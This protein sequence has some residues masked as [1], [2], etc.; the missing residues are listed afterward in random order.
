MSTPTVDPPPPPSPFDREAVTA[1]I[2][3][4]HELAAGCEGVLT[5]LPV[6]ENSPPHPQRFRIGDVDGMVAA[7]MSYSGVP[8]CNLYAPFATMC[9]SVLADEAHKNRFH[10]VR[11]Y[12][13]GLHW[14]GERRLDE[15]L[16]KYLGAA[17]SDYSTAIGKMFLVALVARIFEPGCKSD[18]MI[19]LEGPQGAMKSAACRVIAGEWFSDS[20]PEVRGSKDLA[21][22]LRG[23]WLIEVSELS[24]MTR[25]ETNTLKAFVTREK[26]LY[27]PPYGRHEVIEPR[28]CLFVGTVN[29]HEYLRDATGGRR[30]WPLG[31]GVIDLVSLRKDRDQL[32]A[33]AVYLYQ[34]G[35]RWWPSPEFEAKH[36]REEQEARYVEDPWRSTIAVHLAGLTTKRVTVGGVAKD[37]LMLETARVGMR[38]AH[39]IRDV[40]TQLEWRQK[41]TGSAR[42]YEPQEEKPT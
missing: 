17:K 27:R 31:V 28:Q 2:T 15:W 32:F 4:L 40:L 29:E 3:M 1:H 33:E 36:I 14:D 30:F 10:P 34:A 9:A 38:E 22:H 6:W 39:R 24:A 35:E 7:A 12:L 13:S 8:G 18:Y 25:T 19:I 37:A 42:W 26:E 21:Q 11:L 20:L 5:L 23:K 16:H 41:R